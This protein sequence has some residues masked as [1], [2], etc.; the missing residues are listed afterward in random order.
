MNTHIDYDWDDFEIDEDERPD[1]IVT[2]PRILAALVLLVFVAVMTA[3][4][5]NRVPMQLGEVPP[6]LIALWTCNDP[7]RSDFYV[8]FRRQF[9][10]L[11]TGGTGH[12]KWRVVGVNFETIGE[13]EHFTLYYRDLAGSRLVME[14]LLDRSGEDLRFM[15]RPGTVWTRFN[16]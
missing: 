14:M 7:E 16:L 9:V 3:G 11:G 6:S 13:V 8:E 10:R 12:V 1:P 5:M 4:I 15:N 2:T